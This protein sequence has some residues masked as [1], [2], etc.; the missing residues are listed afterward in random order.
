MTRGS[1][2][3]ARIIILLK[4]GCVHDVLFRKRCRYQD[5]LKLHKNSIIISNNSLSLNTEIRYGHFLINMDYV[6]FISTL[7]G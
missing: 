3:I 2:T 6:Q 4:N 1:A 5:G 7:Y